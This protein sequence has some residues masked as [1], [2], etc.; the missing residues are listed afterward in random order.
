METGETLALIRRTESPQKRIE[1]NE[2]DDHIRLGPGRRLVK[3]HARL[4]REGR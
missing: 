4:D 1:P 3:I 2:R